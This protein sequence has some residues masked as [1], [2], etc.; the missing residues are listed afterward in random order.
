MIAR[1]KNADGVYIETLDTMTFDDEGAITS[2]RAYWSPESSIRR[3]DT[4]A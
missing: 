3:G 2:M 1:P 4:S